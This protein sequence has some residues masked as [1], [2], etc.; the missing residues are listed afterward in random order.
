MTP[1]IWVF[2]ILLAGCATED[3]PRSPAPAPEGPSETRQASDERD[4]RPVVVFLGNSLT[5][6]MGVSPLEAYPA[7]VQQSIDQAG[8]AFRVVN[9]GVSGE[10]TAGGLRRVEAIL[11]EGPTVLVVALG[12]NDALRGVPPAQVRENLQGILDRAR[13]SSQILRIVIMGMLAPPNLGQAYTNAF[14]EVFPDVAVANDADLVP[15]LLE[16]VAADPEL[17]QADGIH[18][19]AE[20][21]RVMAETVWQVLEPSLR[22]LSIDRETRSSETGE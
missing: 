15:F 20:G 21:H 7:L 6:G 14:R 13:S 8:L 16:G 5:A 3:A 9:A 10:T 17:N 22:A 19:T 12:G 18:P 1:T 4:A 11:G 2:A